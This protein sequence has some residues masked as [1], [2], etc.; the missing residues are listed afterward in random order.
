MITFIDHETDGVEPT[1]SELVPVPS[2]DAIPEPGDQELAVAAAEP[3][4]IEPVIAATPAV[5]DPD[6]E[7]AEVVDEES[8]DVEDST[9]AGFMSEPLQRQPLAQ[10]KVRAL[11]LLQPM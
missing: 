10:V 8:L 5:A 7:P 4:T 11:L 2:L 6:D 9:L 3:E 1:E